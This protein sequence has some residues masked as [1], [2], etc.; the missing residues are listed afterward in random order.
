MTRVDELARR[1][2]ATLGALLEAGDC[3]G[4]L[5]DF[6]IRGPVYAGRY[7]RIYRIDCKDPAS[8][9][10]AKFC[11]LPD[12][13]EPDRD[14][15]ERQFREQGEFY[16]RMRSGS[17]YRVPAPLGISSEHALIFLEWIEAEQLPRLLLRRRLTRSA[18][19][20]LSALAGSWL[21][22]FHNAGPRRSAPADTEALLDSVDEVLAGLRGTGLAP[23]FVS[24]A[25]ALLTVT[26]PSRLELSWRHGDFQASNVLV[27]HG[28][29]YGID[30]AFSEVGCTLLDAAHF[31]NDLE[32]QTL[33]PKGLHLRPKLAGMARSFTEAYFEGM[34]VACRAELEWF[35]LLDSLRFMLRYH[36]EFNAPGKG[37]Y[38]KAIL[39]YS[40]TAAMKR[41]RGA[42][43]IGGDSR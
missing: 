31:L 8:A 19:R 29:A 36:E 39:H 35:R 22:A 27:N 2:T 1:D 33:L 17:A 37:W 43:I 25:A 26:V 28:T 23:G 38:M 16:A 41:L 14:F 13:P 4:R 5:R 10:A 12:C 3:I 9:V 18:A 11:A 20:R 42:A 6:S 34:P 32:R 24:R 21:R 7:S 15:A 30:M 40:I